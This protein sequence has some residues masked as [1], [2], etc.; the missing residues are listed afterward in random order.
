MGL[1]KISVLIVSYNTQDALDRCLGCVGDGY[2]VIVVDNASRDGSVEMI[3]E[4]FPAVK[5]I[6]NPDNVG[7]GS[8]NNQAASAATGELHLYLNSDAYAQPGA[9]DRLAAVFEDDSIVAAGGRLLNPDGSLQ[10]STANKLKLWAVLC[11]QLYLEK[12][13]PRSSLMSPYWNTPTLVGYPSPADTAQ[14]MGACLMVRANL[15]R[16]DER[17][18]L[19]CEDTDLCLRL[20]R[21]GRIVYVKD[22]SFVHDLGSS[23]AHDPVRGVIRYNWGKELYFRIHEGRAASFLCLVLD[24]IGAV[25]RV[26]AWLAKSF[27]SGSDRSREMVRGFWRVVTAPYQDPTRSSRGTPG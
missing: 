9:I 12:L 23:S 19:Y 3:R 5:L 17:Y 16:F 4:R 25:C 1:H 2:E 6:A 24:R 22:A 20:R 8:A 7:F 27:G 26:I 18:F 11:E 21:H 15:E 10:N 13:F 14:V